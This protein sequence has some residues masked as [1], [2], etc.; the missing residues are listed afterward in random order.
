[1]RRLA[2]AL[3][4][5]LATSLFADETIRCESKGGRRRCA[6]D[7]RGEVSIS[8]RRQLSITECVE[9]QNWGW[10]RGEV[11]VT[12]G[13]RAD[14]LIVPRRWERDRD[15]DRDRRDRYDGQ[16]IVC[17]S[18][19]RY[20]RCDVRIPFGV[21]LERQL[22]RNDCIRG[23]SWDYDR[24]GIWVDNGCRAEFF[25]EGDRDDH[26]GRRELE[27]VLCESRD[28]RNVFC[29]ADTRFGVELTRQIS[30]SECVYRRSWGYDDRGIWVRD[31][32]RAEFTLGRR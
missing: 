13:C 32:C 23:R 12:D 2:L 27:R 20:H 6:F 26:H 3:F 21:R 22:S 18:N 15:R 7:T 24:N 16:T 14:F 4:L 11:W 19:G 29:Q 5:L 28:G 1:M 30:T 9:G 17:E 8:V 10:E 31:G 25:V